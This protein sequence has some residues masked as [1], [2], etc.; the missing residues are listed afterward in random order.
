MSFAPLSHTL[1]QV[2]PKAQLILT[3]IVSSHAQST[4]TLQRRVRDQNGSVGSGARVYNPRGDR[5]V[6]AFDAHHRFVANARYGLPLDGSRFVE[7]WQPADHQFP[8]S[9]CRIRLV[10]TS[11]V[12]CES[13]P[14]KTIC[15]FPNT[16]E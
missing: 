13:Q 8:F 16:R 11:A 2:P 14:L 6:S 7:G 5:G 10:E 9:N 1:L 12:R 15:V 3:A 4:A